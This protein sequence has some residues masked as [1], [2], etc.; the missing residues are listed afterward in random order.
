[1]TSLRHFHISSPPVNTNEHFLSSH[2]P[3]S[4]WIQNEARKVEK[5]NRFNAPLVTQRPVEQTNANESQL[6]SSANQGVR[7]ADQLSHVQRQICDFIAEQVS[8]AEIRSLVT[9]DLLGFTQR[10]VPLVLCFTFHQNFVLKSGSGRDVADCGSNHQIREEVLLRVQPTQRHVT[11]IFFTPP[12]FKFLFSLAQS[13][14]YCQFCVHFTWNLELGLGIYAN[15]DLRL[16]DVMVQDE[17][18]LTASSLEEKKNWKS[19]RCVMGLGRNEKVFVLTRWYWWRIY[20]ARTCFRDWVN[21]FMT[22]LAKSSAA[23]GCFAESVELWESFKLRH[24]SV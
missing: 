5:E 22:F 10:A 20:S 6:L 24:Y 23:A 15:A 7:T 3:N 21:R 8:K 16:H 9:D 11:S 18:R 14:F 4:Q 19:M 2:V 13:H 12:K 1:M 17:L